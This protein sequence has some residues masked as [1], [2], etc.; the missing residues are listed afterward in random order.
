MNVLDAAQATVKAY[1]G[2]AESL[3]PRLEMTGALLRAKAN[4]A[5][6]RN[7]F[8]LQE[9]DRL[10][11]VTGDHRI[12]HAMAH[13]HGYVLQ[14]CDELER[15]REQAQCRVDALVLALMQATGGLAGTIAEAREDGVI[16]PNEAK[17]TSNAGMQVQKI[18]VDLVAAIQN[19]VRLG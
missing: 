2:G 9:I 16:T 12:L 3:A 7:H 13:A 15:E 4:P 5:Q 19:Q 10:M 14:R 6:D 18:V 17:D 1:P 8:T 11:D